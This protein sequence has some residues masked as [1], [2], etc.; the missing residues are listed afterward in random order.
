VQIKRPD[1]HHPEHHGEQADS[2]APP[3]PGDNSGDLIMEPAKCPYCTQTEFGVTYEPPPFRRGLSYSYNSSGLGAIGT[4]MSSTSSLNSGPLSTSTAPSA[5]ANRRRA[6]S[7]S[8]NAPG[9]ITTDRIRPDWSTK[10][11]AALAQQRRRAAAAD[12]LHHAAF[13]MGNNE[14]RT[15]FGRPSRFG[16][17]PTRDPRESESPAP[18]PNAP[19]QQ[20][21]T[22]DPSAGPQIEPRT[23]SGRAGR[24]RIDAEHLENMMLAEA[25]RLSLADEEERRKKS[26]KEARK[27][28][29]KRE[30][31]DRKATKGQ[32][33]SS[34]YGGSGLSSASASSLSLG[35]SGLRHGNSGTGNLRVE[36]SVAS[37]SGSAPQIPVSAPASATTFDLDENK[38]KAVDRGGAGGA[39][40]NTSSLSALPI[41]IGLS[42]PSRGSSHLRQ[43]SNASSVSS[44]GI[45]S[46]PG[47]YRA[48]DD[49]RGSGLSLG[50]DDEEAANASQ[51]ESMFNFRSLAEMVGVPIDGDAE[52]PQSE[53]EHN[54]GAKE[55]ESSL[56]HEEHVEHVEKSGHHNEPSSEHKNSGEAAVKPGGSLTPQLMVT[57]ETPAPAEA[58]DE[59]SKQLG[60]IVES[61]EARNEVT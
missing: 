29:K 9:V 52:S 21:G 36:A 28:A 25:I 13:V 54:P 12:A 32:S 5:A 16:R 8:A 11:A 44:S 43:M 59:G 55:D 53:E 47:S 1:P 31:D 20:D 33:R 38:G 57:P 34:V 23:S 24:E 61:A 39:S 18:S 37:A 10:L 15:I 58:G 35:T 51:A 50:A 40:S 17:R 7:L 49:P 6:Q 48:T 4:A 60:H 3:N 27:E 2:D 30:K 22:L 46:M 14:S 56:P 45:D 42:Q 26:D 19:Q 41:P